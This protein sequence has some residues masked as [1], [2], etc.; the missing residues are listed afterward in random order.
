MCSSITVFSQ[1]DKGNWMVGGN[2]FIKK[3]THTETSNNRTLEYKRQQVNLSPSIS[4]FVIDKGAVGIRSSI[5]WL[6][7]KSVLR[8]VFFNEIEYSF[9]PFI[10]YYLLNAEKPINIITEAHYSF[11]KLIHEGKTY[12]QYY[13]GM[14][15]PVYFI[16]NKVGIELLLG[17]ENKQEQGKDRFGDKYSDSFKGFITKFGL[18]IHLGNNK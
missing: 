8:S 11:G 16:N 1:I 9:G 3:Y 7:N 2:G 17:Y 15:G 6:R 18:Q 13:S 14:A 5:D 4:Y 12:T 10:R